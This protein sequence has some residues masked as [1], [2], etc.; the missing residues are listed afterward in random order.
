M[1][2]G[3]V[4]ELVTL[5]GFEIDKKPLQELD[6]G[7]NTIKASLKAVG[8]VTAATAGAIGF[9]LN[10]AGGDEQ[11][12]IAFETMLGSAE[13]AKDLMQEIKDFADVTP[14][15]TEEVVQA[16]KGLLAF[17]VAEE[18][19]IEKTRVL[20]DIASGVGKDKFGT[21]IRGFGKIKTKGKATMEELNM[22]L[23]AG[24]PIL[25]ELA[26]GFGV[27]KEE[28]FKMVST[29]KVGFSDVDKALKSMAT[30]SGKFAGLMAK[31]SKSLFGLMSTIQGQLDNFAKELGNELLPAAKEVVST[32]LEWFA[33]NRKILKAGAIKFVK[34]L[35]MLFKNMVQLITTFARALT[36]LVGIF[37]GWNKVLGVTFKIFSAIMGL[38]LLVGIGLVTKAIFGLA[39]AWKAMGAAALFAQLKMM[40]I[41]LAIGAIV[42][43]IA[44]IAEDII[45]FSQGRDSVFGRMLEGITMIF[46]KMSEKFQ[47]FGTIGKFL[48]SALL[49]PVRI[50]INGFKSLLAIVDVVRGKLSFMQGLKKIGG[51]ILSNFG[52]GNED[53]LS[54]ALGIGN[55]L[56]SA[57]GQATA[58]NNP[59]A[60]LGT[61]P[62]KGTDGATKAVNVDAK[63]EINLNVTGM[64]PDD[65]KDLVTTTLQGELGG[66]LRDTVRDGESQ[67]ER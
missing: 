34:N 27:N 33:A 61:T 25:D 21:L 9:L 60:G 45:A 8:V 38:G 41:P 32:F 51:N 3:V 16:S 12:L 26:K 44:L 22:F 18:D 49:T 13:K 43:A 14:F 56:G 63:N 46:G 62:F 28:I 66:M 36:G 29:G 20:G 53:S 6:A 54:G 30:G 57:V 42:T 50:I 67:I 31:Q 11:T 17:G 2:G 10:R 19:I 15:N 39:L 37:G 48:V 58:N 4:R 64:N 55:N 47:M 52:I 59:V 5:W 65:A 24:V 1:A 7:I 23:E 40:L 35:V